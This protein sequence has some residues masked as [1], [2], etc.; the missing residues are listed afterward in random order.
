MFFQNIFFIDNVFFISFFMKL[1]V[2]KFSSTTYEQMDAHT[3]IQT[4]QISTCI[5]T[6]G[7]KYLN[8]LHL[9]R[10]KFAFSFC[11]SFFNKYGEKV[12]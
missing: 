5:H 3:P 10:F 9:K 11:S 2:K 8:T 1:S 6:D 7:H 4:L 12:R